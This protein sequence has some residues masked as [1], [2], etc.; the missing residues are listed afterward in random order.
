MPTAAPTPTGTKLRF[1]RS[2]KKRARRGH[3]PRGYGERSVCQL[4]CAAR[5]SDLSRSSAKCAGSAATARIVDTRASRI[6]CVEMQRSH[7]HSL[8]ESHDRAR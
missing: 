5:A 1:F 4:N 7:Y 3:I 6:F 2:E 8:R